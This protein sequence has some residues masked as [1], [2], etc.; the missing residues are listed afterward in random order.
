V[1]YEDC[2]AE[3]TGRSELS[4]ALRADRIR[5]RKGVVSKLP[6]LGTM[7]DWE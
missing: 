7:E 5:Q 1:H 3:L 4:V 6:G 2:Q